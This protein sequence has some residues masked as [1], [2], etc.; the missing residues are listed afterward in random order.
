MAKAMDDQFTIPVIGVKVGWDSILGLFPGVGDFSGLAT[1]GYLM[2]KAYQLR[3][4]IWVQVRML[5]NALIDF[6][7]GMIP[8]VGDLFDLVWRSNRRNAK[9]I[10]DAVEKSERARIGRRT[11]DA[12]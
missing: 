9:L 8:I 2:W 11:R 1:H 3:V 12:D 10:S 6:L 5:I 7:V 4:G